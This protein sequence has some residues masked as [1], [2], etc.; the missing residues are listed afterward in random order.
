VSDR[1][2]NKNTNEWLT[3]AMP[4]VGLGNN[5]TNTA[6]N[7]FLSGLTKQCKEKCPQRHSFAR[8]QALN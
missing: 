7:K 1:N 8:Y 3:P 2:I 6:I 5:M 4:N